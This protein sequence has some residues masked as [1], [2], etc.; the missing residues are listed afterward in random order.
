MDLLTNCPFLCCSAFIEFF[1][2]G[3][4]QPAHPFWFVYTVFLRVCSC[5]LLFMSTVESHLASNVNKSR[6]VQKDLQVAKKL[7]EEED[8]W[9]KIQGQKQHIDL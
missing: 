3:A 2:T 7:Q 6:L 5:Y 9:A 4:V 8:E 1:I